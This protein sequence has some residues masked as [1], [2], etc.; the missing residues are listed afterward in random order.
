MHIV[1]K[2]DVDGS[3]GDGAGDVLVADSLLWPPVAPGNAIGDVDGDSAAQRQE[4]DALPGPA[5]AAG[6][7]Q[8]MAPDLAPAVRANGHG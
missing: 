1:D 5:V 8:Q 4:A 7:M 2:Q 6:C 3:A